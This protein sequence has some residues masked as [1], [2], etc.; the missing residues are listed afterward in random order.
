MGFPKAS[1]RQPYSL[2]AIVDVAVNEFL[3]RGYDGT[4]MDDLARAAGISKSS[5]YHHIS[6][7]EQLLRLGVSRALDAL[8][9]VLDEPEATSG[10]HVDRVRHILRRTADVIVDKTPEVALLIR[11]RGNTETERWAL[12]RRREFDRT[13]VRLVRQAVRNGDIRSD[14]DPALLTRL[15]F[16][17]VN[18]V[19]EWYQPG[20]RQTARQLADA[21]ERVALT[22]MQ[23][24]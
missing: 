10:A 2:D 15:L 16:G 4:S 19:V 11:V 6:G 24:T 18:S 12:E 7:K 9:A 22:G 23:A 17:M 8:F 3:N 5:F 20:G 21:V 14:V 1:V 13:V